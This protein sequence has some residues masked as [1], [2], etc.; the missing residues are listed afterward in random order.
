MGVE[1]FD[2]RVMSVSAAIRYTLEKAWLLIKGESSRRTRPS[3]QFPRLAT[4]LVNGHLKDRFAGE[5]HCAGC[6]SMKAAADGTPRLGSPI[7]WRRLG[8][9]H[10]ITRVVEDLSAL[11]EP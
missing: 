8:T 9:I 2:F 1:G 11:P 3:V 5:N 10:H 7:V 4:Q 6:A